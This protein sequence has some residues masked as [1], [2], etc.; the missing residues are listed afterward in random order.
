MRLKEAAGWNQVEDDW[1]NV[2]RV[3]PGG[4]FGIDAEEMLAA[5]ASAVRFG[6]ELAWIGMVL[7]H[8]SCRGRGLARRLM[9]HSIEY[10]AG[11]DTDWIKL[12]AT[13]MGRPLYA[14]LG[15]EDEG[16]VERWG[17]AAG[18]GENVSA[19]QQSG[20]EDWSGEAWSGLDREAFGEDRA[21]LLRV[22]APF[23]SA[24]VAGQGYAMG[25]AGSK[26]AYFGPCVSRSPEA[27]RAL[28]C[29]FLARHP[30]EAVYW[31]L[32]PENRAAA[33]LARAFGFAPVRR[34]VRMARQTAAGAP[35]LV[36][37]D[38]YI[39]AIAGFEYG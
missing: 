8:P 37:N 36:H 6:P 7:T 24:A 2:M 12:D 10:L 3:A 17:R 28:L 38:S 23:G 9:E 14:R 15:F 13:D 26:A 22:L 16:P 25:R 33:D 27:A 20:L 1:R 19:H 30:G 34:L 39:Y 11:L 18:A 5:T 35:P 4:C 32:L 31:D 29:W 21:A